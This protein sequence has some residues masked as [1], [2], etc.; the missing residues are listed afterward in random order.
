MIEQTA[1]EQENTQVIIR[2]PVNSQKKDIQDLHYHNKH[3]SPRRLMTQRK[4]NTIARF[5]RRANIATAQEIAL[6]RRACAKGSIFALSSKIASSS[7]FTRSRYKK[8]ISGF[9]FLYWTC[10]LYEKNEFQSRTGFDTVI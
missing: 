8:K 5:S 6:R 1:S 10:T 9:S 7:H 3:S 2:G 4:W